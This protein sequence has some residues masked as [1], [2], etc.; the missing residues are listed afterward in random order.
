MYLELK[1]ILPQRRTLVGLIFFLSPLGAVAAVNL[2]SGVAVDYH[3]T[4]ETVIWVTGFGGALLNALGSV[5]G[6]FLCDV[7][8]RW[9]AFILVGSL[10]AISTISML[11]APLS[12]LTF[13]IGTSAYLFIAGLCYA[14]FNALALEVS[15]NEEATAGT[16]TSFF[17]AVGNAP[18]AYMAWLDGQGYKFLGVRGLLGIDTA[19]NVVGALALLALLRWFRSGRAVSGKVLN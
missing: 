15:G 4:S 11:L 14:A 12:P 1:T 13:V 6:G 5:A 9:T 19:G 3:A 2:F 16:R 7:M 8:D 10:S 17:E 18:I